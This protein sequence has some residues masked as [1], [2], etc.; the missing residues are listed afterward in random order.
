MSQNLTAEARPL[1]DIPKTEPKIR[2]GIVLPEDDDRSSS[3]QLEAGKPYRLSLNGEGH[4]IQVNEPVMGTALVEGQTVVVTIHADPVVEL[5]GN[6][7]ILTPEFK[8][9][10]EKGAGTRVEGLVAGR[11]FHW[12]KRIAQTLLGS[13]EFHAWDGKLVV[14]NELPVEAYLAGVVTGEM[15]GECP[16]E[17]MK[18]QIVAG[19]SWMFASGESKHQPLPFD[20]CNDDCCQRY[21]GTGDLSAKAIQ[22]INETRGELIVTQGGNVCDAKYSKSCGGI[23]ADPRLVWGGDKPGQ[24]TAPD[25]PNGSEVRRFDPVTEANAREYLTGNWL[26]ETDVFCSPNVVPENELPKYLGRVDEAGQY[27]RWTVKYSREEL[28]TLLRSKGGF[29][30]LQTLTGLTPGTRGPSGRLHSITVSYLD[31]DGKA[32]QKTI[33]D[34]YHIRRILHPSFLYSSAFVIDTVPGSDGHPQDYVFHGGGW[35]H[36]AGLCQIG[37]LGMGVKGY[38]YQEILKHYFK[39][40]RLEK[41]YP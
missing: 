26:Q 40:T 28:T 12:R 22:A 37:A 19:R 2:V 32:V 21:Q 20:R 10:L 41:A 16:I 13:L 36:G 31:A 25:A 15:G 35:G 29:K 38:G 1:S 39:D 6:P 34:Q 33:E 30:N 27:F 7:V 3:F 5:K 9:P 14:V 23:M 11:I 8:Q 24:Y 17:F 18:A 4:S